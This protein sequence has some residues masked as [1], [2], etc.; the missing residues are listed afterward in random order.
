MDGAS[1]PTVGTP[2]LLALATGLS[3]G[4]SATPFLALV[5]AL[6]PATKPRLLPGTIS[7]R[8]RLKARV[9]ALNQWFRPT[10]DKVSTDLCHVQV[11]PAPVTTLRMRRSWRGLTERHKRSI[12]QQEGR[13][14]GR[15]LGAFSGSGVEVDQELQALVPGQPHGVYRVAHSPSSVNE[16]VLR[17]RSKSQELCVSQGTTNPR[18][19]TVDGETKPQTRSEGE[20]PHIT[21]SPPKDSGA[22]ESR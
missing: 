8:P 2:G 16:A 17:L 7:P 9:S 12:V 18:R 1:T 5:G 21:D 14:A 20:L 10:T 3:P 22:G 6:G 19:V 13:I 11:A 15:V 4:V